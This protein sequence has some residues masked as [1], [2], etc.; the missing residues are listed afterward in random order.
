V[1][2][3]SIAGG[4]DLCGCLVAGDPTAPVRAG[5]IQRPAL[6]M[7]IDV[8][9][10]E[11]HSLRDSPGSAGELVCRRPFPSMPLGFWHDD[12]GER[13]HNAYY[14][15]FDGIW[16]HGDHASFTASGGVIIHGRSDTT[17]NPGGVRIG[18]AEIYRVVEA[19]PEVAEALAFGQQWED[20]VRIVLLVR[21]AE[22]HVLDDDLRSEIRA[23]IRSACTPR[24]VPAVI[25]QVDDLP[26]TRS[27]KLVELAV[28]DAVHGRPV[29]NTEAIVN[30]EAIDAIVALPE[31]RR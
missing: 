19:L 12:S 4:T 15:R 11:G 31:L 8:Y 27:N 16:A 6:G 29:R 21:V 25:A 10:D 23:R 30:P 22:G 5:E 2:L 13:Y 20:D 18:T 9:D 14:A 1:H 3:A 7:D 28:A 17:L 26:R 24:H